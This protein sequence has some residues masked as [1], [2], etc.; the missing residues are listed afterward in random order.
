[1]FQ[2]VDANVILPTWNTKRKVAPLLKSYNLSFLSR[3]KFGFFGH[4]TRE[5][6]PIP[7]ELLWLQTIQ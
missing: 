7:T 1:M 2:S 6:L 3:I 5:L 4:P